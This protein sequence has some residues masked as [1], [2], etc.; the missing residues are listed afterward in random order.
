MT[1]K[2]FSSAGELNDYVNDNT[3]AQAAI[4]AIVESRSQWYIFHF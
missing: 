1:V 4:V 2:F 3:I